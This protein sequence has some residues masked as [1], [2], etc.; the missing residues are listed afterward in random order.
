MPPK[1]AA[2]AKAPEKKEVL[3]VFGNYFVPEMRTVINLLDLN[4]I[5]Y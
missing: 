4:E 5:P 3:K 2:G 1:Q